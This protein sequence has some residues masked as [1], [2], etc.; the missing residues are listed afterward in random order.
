M[1]GS[2][3]YDRG[4]VS[5]ERTHV[6]FRKRKN[7]SGEKPFESTFL[8]LLPPADQSYNVEP[9]YREGLFRHTGYGRNIDAFTLRILRV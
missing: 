3:S 5:D 6:R 2:I 8:A 1:R 9:E 7:R 4:E